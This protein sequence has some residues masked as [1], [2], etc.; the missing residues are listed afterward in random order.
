MVLS[1]LRREGTFLNNPF[2]CALIALLGGVLVSYICYLVMKVFILGNKNLAAVA[3]IRQ[4]IGIA[5]FVGT[6]FLAKKLGIDVIPTIIGA[7]LGIT[8]PSVVFSSRLVSLC[9]KS[10][11]ETTA[12]SEKSEGGD[13]K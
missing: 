10:P 13:N 7:A 3:P 4:I 5:Y 1:A 6:Y 11:S 2:V 9:G 8:L 12:G